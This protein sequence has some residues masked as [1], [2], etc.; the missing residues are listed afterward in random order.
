MK[1]SKP[2]QTSSTKTE[3]E[4]WWT[5]YA[6][7][8]AVLILWAG[9][10]VLL[11]PLKN[12]GE[13]GD[14]F[15]A[16]NAL[17]SGLAFAGLIATLH[18]QRKELA[19]QRRE[20]ALQRKEIRAS[21]RVM[22]KQEQALSSQADTLALQ[23]F[24]ATLMSLLDCHSSAVAGLQFRYQGEIRTGRTA[25]ESLNNAITSSIAV[26]VNSRRI[27]GEV[28]QQVL[29]KISSLMHSFYCKNTNYFA[30]MRFMLGYVKRAEVAGIQ[31]YLNLVEA[32]I[33]VLDRQ[34]LMY[35]A[36]DESKRTHREMIGDFGLLAGFTVPETGKDEIDHTNIAWLIAS[37]VL[38]PKSFIKPIW[39]QEKPLNVKLA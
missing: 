3:S 20:L 6:A 31:I 34:V 37:E 28:K 18:Y 1:I 5:L 24:E 11:W 39:S 25:L 2:D 38:D 36:L 15:G 17:F 22:R 35:L 14:M 8:C 4:S 12:R 19:L 27:N 30:G 16:I 23:R 21:R 7:V 32:Q 29:E 33:T 13:F 10:G 9:S 26:A